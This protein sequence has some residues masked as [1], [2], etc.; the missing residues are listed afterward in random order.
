[1]RADT[2]VRLVSSPGFAVLETACFRKICGE[3]ATTFFAAR[4]FGQSTAAREP[5]VATFDQLQGESGAPLKV[6]RYD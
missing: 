6:E 3:I 5:E 1:M 2:V 4:R